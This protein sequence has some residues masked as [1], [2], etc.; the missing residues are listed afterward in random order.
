[1]TLPAG[2]G[3]STVAPRTASHG[4]SG[5]S[6]YRSWPSARNSGCARTRCRGTGRRC[7]RAQPRAALAGD[8][9][10]LPVGDAARDAHLDRMRD[11]AHA[12]L[13][14]VLQHAK[15]ELELGPMEGLVERDF[16]HRLVVG[17]GPC[18]G[19]GPAWRA[20]R[21]CPA[22]PANRSANRCPRRSLPPGEWGSQSGGGRKSS[23]VGSGP[24]LVVG[25]AFFRVL[26]RLVGLRDLLELGLGVLL[27]GDVRMVLARQLAVGVLDVSAV[28]HR[29]RRPGWRSSPCISWRRRER[30]AVDHTRAAVRHPLVAH[31]RQTW[32][33]CGC[34][35]A[36]CRQFE[37]QN[38]KFAS[39]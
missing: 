29:A 3:S 18:C 12:A 32:M 1:M 2:V 36:S 24:S 23:P 25:G 17:T 14:V 16:R 9:Q 15:V 38:V 7:A 33:D 39:M 28:A 37:A 10:L 34:L 26:Q 30:G 8:A 27:L 11:A 31:R 35:V 4:A 13:L 19:R 5:R 21:A 6:T 22:R 20:P